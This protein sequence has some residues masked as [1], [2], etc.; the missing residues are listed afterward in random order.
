MNIIDVM[1]NKLKLKSIDGTILGIFGGIA[2]SLGGLGSAIV[3]AEL[4]SVNIGLSKFIGAVIFPVGIVMIMC[5]RF[6]LFTSN[7]LTVSCID[8]E[9][10]I[11]NVGIFLS[12]I[13]TANFIGA[14]I[15]A[16]VS[17]KCGVLSDNAIDYVNGIA[18]T[19]SQMNIVPMFIK[20]IFCNILVCIAT[21]MGIKR[22]PLFAWIPV[23]LFVV[24]GFEHSI[25][26][27][28]YFMCNVFSSTISVY[29]IFVNLSVVTLGNIVG[30]VIVS[31]L[32]RYLE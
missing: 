16:Y 12:K 32:F 18:Q 20:A 29:G 13:W 19:K 14:I 4:N 11:S 24:C 9:H 27:M 6:E 22:N 10:K 15:V 17:V 21:T 26:N 1:K 23:G 25:A 2:V 7:V 31:K 5:M 30:G 8:K 28:F 3:C